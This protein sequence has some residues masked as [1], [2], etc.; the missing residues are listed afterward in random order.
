[1]V[2][3]I[4]LKMLENNDLEKAERKGTASRR[5]SPG[6][7]TRSARMLFIEKVKRN[8]TLGKSV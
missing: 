4:C 3:S 6:N 8:G 5:L 7:R 1:M 2:S